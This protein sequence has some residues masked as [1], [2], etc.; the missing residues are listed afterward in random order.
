MDGYFDSSVIEEGLEE[1]LLFQEAAGSLAALAMTRCGGFYGS[2][3][4]SVLRFVNSLADKKCNTIGEAV[5][6][7]KREIISKFSKAESIFGPAVLYTL[8]GDPA[9][10][11][12]A[13][14]KTATETQPDPN[15][16][17]KISFSLKGFP[18]PFNAVATIRY[19]IDF[20]RFVTLEIFNLHGQKINTRIAKEHLPGNYQTTWDGTDQFGIGVP[21]GLYF[22][23][24]SAGNNQEVLKLILLK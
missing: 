6:N 4:H 13:G 11:I 7:T 16:I 5:L 18:N 9:L 14:A 20:P 12:P 10:T 21:T 15:F 22:A 1:R 23:R 2:I 3:M 17:P 8:L 19:V 24:I